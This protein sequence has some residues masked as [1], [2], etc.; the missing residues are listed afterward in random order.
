MNLSEINEVEQVLDD[1]GDW[2]KR[3]E[4]MILAMLGSI[5]DIKYQLMELL[6]P[7]AKQVE[8]FNSN[9]SDFANTA[10]EGIAA[11][12]REHGTNEY[13][14]HTMI[15]VGEANADNL[16]PIDLGYSFPSTAHA[17]NEAVIRHLFYWSQN[18][19]NYFPVKGIPYS[20]EEISKHRNKLLNEFESVSIENHMDFIQQIGEQ[21]EVEYIKTRRYLA[22][23]RSR[24]DFSG[25]KKLSQSNANSANNQKIKLPENPDVYELCKLLKSKPDSKSC[26]D[27]AREYVGDTGVNW[28]SL[29]SQA[30]R[31]K[32]LWEI[33]SE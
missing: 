33:D 17:C 8:L 26:N 30:R 15:I 16:Q 24:L 22:D 18:V 12:L 4:S 32:Y 25:D 20:F 21:S 14:M 9:Y 19:L 28:E 13:S 2:R 27:I 5:M 31:F 1:L 10:E 6:D 7:D 29:L 3:C 23:Y 11:T